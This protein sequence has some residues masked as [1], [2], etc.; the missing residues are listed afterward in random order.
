MM[1]IDLGNPP[2][3]VSKLT[4]YFPEE[5]ILQALLKDRLIQDG[6]DSLAHP[7]KPRMLKELP[8]LFAAQ[9]YVLGS[10]G[11][12]LR[13]DFLTR[14]AFHNVEGNQV[15]VW[16]SVSGGSTANQSQLGLV[17]ITL[18]IPPG[19]RERLLMAQSRKEGFLMKDA[20]EIAHG[21]VT[22]FSLTRR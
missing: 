8:K 7:L 12:E 14:F 9:G 2:S 20:E 5:E 21:K 22:S 13:P 15:A 11:F 10:S 1:N 3:K 4:D 16:I 19:L 6:L 17:K 18:N